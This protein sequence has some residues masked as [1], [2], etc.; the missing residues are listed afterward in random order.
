MSSQDLDKA[1]KS[2]NDS[3]SRANT[4]TDFFNRV[5]DGGQSE[6]VQNP[7]TGAIVPSVQKAVYDQY[8]NDINQIH[9]DVV[10]ANDAAAR[11]E[12]AAGSAEAQVLR[13]DLAAPGGSGLLGIGNGRKQDDLNGQ[14]VMPEDYYSGSGD[15][16]SAIN[17]ALNQS[18]FVQFEN[19]KT[20]ECNGIPNFNGHVVKAVDVTLSIPGGVHT[21]A[22]SRR[23]NGVIGNGLKIKAPSVSSYTATSAAHSGTAKAWDVVFSVPS[24]AGVGVGD[25]MLVRSCAGSGY[26]QWVLGIWKVVAVSAGSITLRNTCHHLTPPSLSGLTSATIRRLPVRLQFNGCNGFELQGAQLF[27]DGG[28]VIAGDWDVASGAGTVGTHGV[29]VSTPDITG[30]ASSNTPI[31]GLGG[32]TT[33][34][35]VAIYGFGEQGVAAEQGAAM[36]VNF[37]ASCANRKRGI[38]VSTNVGCRGKFSITNGNGEDGVICDEGGS[39]AFSLSVSCGNGLNGYWSTNN[40]FLNA[41]NTSAIA[42]LTNGYEAR[43]MSRIACDNSTSA[44]NSASGFNAT[45]GAM[46]DADGAIADTNGS[47]GFYAFNGAVIDANNATSKNNVGW[48]VNGA[49][50]D[51]NFSGG[52]AFAGNSL[53]TFNTLAPGMRGYTNNSRFPFLLDQ[54]IG[55][56]SGN[57][58]RAG[59]DATKFVDIASSSLGDAVVKNNGVNSF[60]LKAQGPFYPSQDNTGQSLGRATERWTVVYAGT[61]TINTSDANEKTTPQRISDAMLD[62]ADD[63]RIDVWKWLESIREK[64]EDSARWHF[65]PIA[66]QV[67]DAFSAHGLNGCDYG[68]LCYDKWDDQFEDE[69]DDSG[70]HTG[71]KKLV[72]AAGERWGIRPDQ[73]LWLKMAASERRASR[74]EDRLTE[75]DAKISI[76]MSK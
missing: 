76:L 38:Y 29:S 48:G 3:A 16:L 47:D 42:N 57:N 58:L 27:L 52:G 34:V 32:I 40:G 25:F 22:S 45:D 5:L 35:D 23:L 11:A 21:Y 6:S 12:A 18:K 1:I 39:G 14:F 33:G 63:I 62:A 46:M 72:A 37:L 36:S 17:S 50:S 55:S 31:V 15:W 66:Q 49:F 9:Q 53:G 56:A 73:C 8:K 64:G 60:V 28:M 70:N 41:T 26:I 7:L 24:S 54:T 30:G 19:G 61:G 2:I 4:T 44:L 13:S 68:L 65:G 51:V 67:R 69:V 59:F 71:N 75:I 43:G 20:Y 74:A 10:D